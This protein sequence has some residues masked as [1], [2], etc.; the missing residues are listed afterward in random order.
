MYAVT[1]WHSGISGMS[2]STR[3]RS[4][5]RSSAARFGRSSSAAA[6][7]SSASYVGLLYARSLLPSVERLSSRN[8]VGSG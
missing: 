3:M 1:Y 5:S 8:V 7:S 4:A 6:A 2:S